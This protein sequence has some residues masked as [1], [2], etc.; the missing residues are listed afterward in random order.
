M[1]KI[2]KKKERKKGE[3]RNENITEKTFGLV[4]LVYLVKIYVKEMVMDVFFPLILA[5]SECLT[6][7]RECIFSHM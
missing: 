1:L 4:N 7:F 2:D 5:F 6:F 3:I